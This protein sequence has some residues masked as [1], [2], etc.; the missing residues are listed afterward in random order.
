M[1]VC[2]PMRH[3]WFTIS[4]LRRNGSQP[5]S[6]YMECNHDAQPGDAHLLS[7][8]IAVWKMVLME[9]CFPKVSCS[10]STAALARAS[11]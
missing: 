8:M 2:L 6:L 9:F 3:K 4:Q 5:Q 10:A 7:E 1:R 11:C